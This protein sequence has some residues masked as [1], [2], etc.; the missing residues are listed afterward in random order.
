MKFIKSEYLINGVWIE[1]SYETW[2]PTN[3]V[4]PP[5]NRNFYEIEKNN[6]TE[7]EDIIFGDFATSLE[8]W[9]LG[10]KF[11]RLNGPARIWKKK[12][13]VVSVE[14]HVYGVHVER[15]EWTYNNGNITIDDLFEHIR[16]YPYSIKQIEMLARHNQWLTEEQ[17]VAI[18]A[19]LSFGSENSL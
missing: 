16:I 7:L 1:R 12:N 8:N 10:D 5:I 17:I 13:K 3:D 15:F 18:Y 19:M 14:W 11:H 6:P 2:D 9:F 4:I